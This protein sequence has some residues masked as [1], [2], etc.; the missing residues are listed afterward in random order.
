VVSAI[1]TGAALPAFPAAALAVGVQVDGAVLEVSLGPPATARG[2]NGVQVRLLAGGGAIVSMH[3]SVHAADQTVGTG[4]QPVATSNAAVM[5]FTHPGSGSAMFAATC[6]LS[7]VRVVEGRL[8]NQSGSQGWFSTVNL[9]TKVTSTSNSPGSGTA[10]QGGD[11]I[12]TGPAGDVITGANEHDVIDAGDAPFKGLEALPP[13]GSPA[14]DDANRNVVDGGGGDDTFVLAAQSGRDVVRGGAGVDLATYAGRFTIGAPGSAGVHVTLDGVA[15]DGDPNVDQPDTAALGEGDNISGDVENL[16]GTKRD[17]RLIGNGSANTLL[18]DEGVDTLT[19]GAGEDLIL[20]R[21]PAS[22]GAGT[23][24]VINCGSPSPSKTTTSI[25]GVF[26]GSESSGSDR[27]QADLADPRPASCE[28]LVD[29]AVDEPAAVGIARAA[30]LDG[31]R[32]AVRLKCPSKAQRT[33]AGELALAGR[34]RGSNRAAFSLT[35]GSARTIRLKLAGRAAKALRRPRAVARVVT[36][37]V[38]LQGEVSRVEL[39]RVR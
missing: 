18:G 36:R 19:G 25:L 3:G 38:G 10:G 31:R 14:L 26:V 23:A 9:P 22:A 5:P 1:L 11:V 7:G 16:T 6:S 34:K 17:D 21:E 12:T 28:L 29:M 39:L 24:D 33:C 15:N 8:W 35:G 2:D 4:C 27:L 32:L 37:E 13:I 20:A 30:R